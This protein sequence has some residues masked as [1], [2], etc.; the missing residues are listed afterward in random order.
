[1]AGATL[2]TTGQLPEWGQYLEYLRAF[3][4]GR[5]GD[6]NYDY[7]RW[8][9][10]LA[11]GAGY[12]AS[13]AALVLLLLRRPDV[14]A[15]ERIATV[16]LAGLTG[17]GI[18]AYSYFNNRSSSFILAVVALP[19]LLAG[20]LW[21]SL[22]LRSWRE[23]TARARLAALAIGSGVA[24]LLVAVAWSSV[25]PR[26]PNS[27]LAHVIPGGDSAAAAMRRL[28]NFPPLSPGAPAGARLLDRY[29]P[30]QEESLV[31]AKPDLETEILLRSNRVNVLPLAAPW[32]DSFVPSVRQA[33]LERA[34]GDLRAGEPML[35]DGNARS[36]FALVRRNP[37][38]DPFAGN[39]ILQS[40]GA[41]PYH[42]APM[43][44]LAI[45]LISRRFDLRPVR[46]GPA[47]LEIVELVKR[48]G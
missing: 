8:S 47:G 23:V 30:G 6:L 27:A 15:R 34:V 5:L 37:S 45:K 18:A 20:A 3:L 22:V 25:A 26:F 29:L 1:L 10:G 35:I 36:A 32:Q 11:V 40:L 14:A 33:D 42:L 31:I 46:L 17:Y 39:P 16:A 43:Q 21:L 9:P 12:L 28:W 2:A 38:F 7:G 24:I 19:A 13:A 41:T 4:S 44:L 48:T